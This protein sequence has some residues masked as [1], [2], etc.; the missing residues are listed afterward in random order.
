[1]KKRIAEWYFSNKKMQVKDYEKFAGEFNPVKFDAKTW[2]ATA[3]NA[4]MKY[5]VI[6]SKHHD[7]FCMFDT[8]LTDYCITKATPWKHDPMKDLAEECRKQGIKLCFYHSIMDWHH[9]DYVPR[10]DW[11]KDARPADGADLNRYLD[12]MKGELTELLTNYGPIGIIWFDGGWEHSAKELRSLEVNAMIRRLQP[13]IIINDRNK[14]PEDYSTPEQNIPANALPGGRLWETCMTM[15]DTWGYA[16]NDTNWKSSEDLIRKLVDIA[17]KGGNFLLNVGPTAEGTFPDAIN[18][19]LADIGAWMKVNSESVY[20][21]TKSPFRQLGFDGRVTAKGNALYLE[22]F[23]WPAG[24]GGIS[25]TGLKTPAVSAH[26]LEGNEPLKIAK[27]ESGG[28]S[29]LSISKPAKV[30]PVATV[31]KLT[32]GGPP[33]VE[34]AALAAKP[35]SDGALDLKAA[36]AELHGAGLQYDWQGLEDERDSIGGSWQPADRVTWRVDLPAAARYRVEIT[37]QCRPE[38][39]AGVL[40]VSDGQASVTGTAKATAEGTRDFRT[41]PIGEMELP[42]GQS[43]VSARMTSRVKGRGIDLHEIRFVP[44]H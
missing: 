14:L 39:A 20:G 34:A 12:Y 35:G 2:V 44:V 31:I 17:S 32:L 13:S 18:Q 7:G 26:S 38:N 5:I 27:T 10:R 43:T 28:V 40:T 1:G 25:L 9:P 24:G 23:N 22:V 16:K 6:T 37:Y 11:E 21:T 33:A 41:D 4:G 19:R 30:N 3:K 29:V 42:K 8:K 36:D 15:N